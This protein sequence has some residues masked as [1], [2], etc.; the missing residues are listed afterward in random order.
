MVFK[1][2]KAKNGRFLVFEKFSDGKKPELKTHKGSRKEAQE[3]IK[4]QW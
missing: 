4:S 1:I 3:W 2:I